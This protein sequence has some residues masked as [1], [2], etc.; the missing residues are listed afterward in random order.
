MVPIDSNEKPK[1]LNLDDSYIKTT[2]SRL[3]GSFT[4]TEPPWFNVTV[5]LSAAW[6]WMNFAGVIF[7]TAASSVSGSYINT[8]HTDWWGL[9][10]PEI[11]VLNKWKFLDL[12]MVLN[13]NKVHERGNPSESCQDISLKAKNV[14]LMAAQE[15]KSDDQQA[16]G[17]CGN[18]EGQKFTKFPGKPSSSC[19]G[20]LLETKG[21]DGPCQRPSLQP[22][23]Y[24]L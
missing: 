2:V 6:G 3:R 8:K 20:V 13:E 7:V 4:N 12:M 14:T 22:H 18:N 17:S 5:S 21:V 23:S 9:L 16:S 10:S 11:K 15:E 24:V 1:T 19:W